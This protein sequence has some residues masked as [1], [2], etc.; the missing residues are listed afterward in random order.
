MNFEHSKHLISDRKMA[1]K[2]FVKHSKVIALLSN[3]GT[4][5]LFVVQKFDQNPARTHHFRVIV[6]LSF[7]EIYQMVLRHLRLLDIYGFK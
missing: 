1:I 5:T 7:S 3:L 6:I 4:T 2:L